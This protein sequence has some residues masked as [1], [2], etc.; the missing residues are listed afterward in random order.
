MNPNLEALK[1]YPFER[2]NTLLD[3]IHPPTQLNPI[4]LSIGEPTYLASSFV[5]NKFQANVHLIQNYPTLRGN[6]ELR[7]TIKSWLIKRYKLDPESLNVETQILPVNGS[8][9]A[10]FSF[11]QACVDVSKKDP[12]VLMPNPFYQVYE[13]AAILANATP[14]F[15]ATTAENN[16]LPDFSQVPSSFWD[17]CQMVYICSPGNP[18]GKVFTRQKYYELLTLSLKH[19][20]IIAA[21]EC[22]S[23]IYQ[24]EANPPI[25]LLQVAQDFG[26]TDYK[27]CIVF[28]SLSKRSNVPGLRS[29]FVAGDEEL[30]TGF[31]KYRTYHGSSMPLPTQQASIECWKDEDHVL[32]NRD[33]Y[34]KK[35]KEVYEILSPVLELEMPEA[36]FYLWL[37]IPIEDDEKFA[38][39]LF[40]LHNVIVLPGSYLSRV[41]GNRCPG[42]GYVRVALVASLEDCIKAA[43]RIRAFIQS[44]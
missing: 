22:Y 8:R 15:L 41:T 34:R 4:D 6:L 26:N 43:K 9:E 38:Q 2:L 3:R 1:P 12:L 18:T 39:E 31:Y 7:E 33:G 23:E 24:D 5:R 36:T 13:G 25:G 29:G 20:F 27:N 10:L 21:D 11:T 35:F 19:N 40:R 30:L 16:F 28:H 42:S 37:K 32:A 17:D 14:V 44:M